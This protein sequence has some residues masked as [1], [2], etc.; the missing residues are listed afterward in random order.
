MFKYISIAIFLMDYTKILKIWNPWWISKK[1]DLNKF[2]IERNK[3]KEIINFLK[4]REI[5]VLKGI[6]RSGKSTIIYQ[7]I[8]YLINQ[9]KIN[10]K[11]I[12]YF[13]FDQ[14]LKSNELEVMDDLL[15][16]YLEIN[17]PKGKIYVFL[18]E[19]QNVELWERWI[20]KEYDLKEKSI[21]FIITGSNNSLLSNKISTALTGRI[22][23]INIYPLSFLEYLLFKNYKYKD[24]DIDENKIKFHFNKFLKKGGF[25]EVVLEKDDY[26]NKKR[27]LEYF[28]NIILRD[29]ITIKDVNETKKLK[30]LAH[31]LITNISS[32][33]T[34]S[35]LGKV[36][37][38]NKATVKEYV[39]Y[40]D[41]S[42]LIFEVNFYSYS[43]KKSVSIQKPKKIYCIDNG[44]REAV[45]FKFWDDNSK[46]IENLVFVDLLRRGLDVYYWFSK[47][48]IDFVVSKNNRLILINVCYSNE[49]PEREIKGFKEFE[50]EYKNIDQKI[51]ITKNLEKEEDGVY[52]IP[53]YKWILKD[54]LLFYK[55]I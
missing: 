47:N 7:I 36:F 51:I 34:Y 18:D 35:K 3:T 38:L 41:Q 54:N 9:K 5:I 19:I 21:K 17:N 52:Y 48:E 14:P 37:G 50:K 46:L 25:P 44:L 16:N 1:V 28:E 31:Y 23:S 33:I 13:N 39:S 45:S 55:E 26:I 6:R 15:N 8:N 20:K 32:Q 24:L 42:F 2:K 30:E 53:I 12:F 22:I 11:N 27:L 40:I 43:L 4:I 29:I 49:I 10:P